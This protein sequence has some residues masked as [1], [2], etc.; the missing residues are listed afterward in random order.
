[1]PPPCLALFDLS[2]ITD[3]AGVEFGR[4]DPSGSINFDMAGRRA[5][6]DK[7]LPRSSVA[8]NIFN[9]LHGDIPARER[10]GNIF[11]PAAGPFAAGV[12][13]L[14]LSAVIS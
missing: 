13:A 1:M 8:N 10:A 14:M 9:F 12:T 3:L 11:E 2:Q 7:P 5:V 4:G 6:T